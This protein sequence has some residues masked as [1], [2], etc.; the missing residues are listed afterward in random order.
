V[1]RSESSFGEESLI[2]VFTAHTFNK[3]VF[4]KN[5]GEVL[6]FKS[7]SSGFPRP[8]SPEWDAN[9]TTIDAITVE[10]ESL[11]PSVG[12]VK[13]LAFS[14]R[15]VAEINQLVVEKLDVSLPKY[16]NYIPQLGYLPVV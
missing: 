9:W 11:K 12:I 8:D 13:F 4:E 1:H 7:D 5:V 6:L 16:P 10:G 3:F 2:W 14:P 15:S